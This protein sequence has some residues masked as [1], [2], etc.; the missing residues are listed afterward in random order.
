MAGLKTRAAILSVLFLVVFL[1]AWQL[2]TA[3]PGAPERE[4]T[5]YEI[6]MGLGAGSGAGMPRPPRSSAWPGRNCHALSTTVVRT[7]RASACSC[8]TP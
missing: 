3:P 2:A 6:M 1:G 7:T 4:L 5:E 8:C